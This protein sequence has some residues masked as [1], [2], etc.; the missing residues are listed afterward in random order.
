[1]CVRYYKWFVFDASETSSR[2]EIYT[3]GCCLMCGI[4]DQAG[5]RVTRRRLILPRAFGVS[6]AGL[7]H[8]VGHGGVATGLGVVSITGGLTTFPSPFNVTKKYHNRRE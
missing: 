1:M 2:L 5:F 7:P 8:V 4:Q 6:F 3:A